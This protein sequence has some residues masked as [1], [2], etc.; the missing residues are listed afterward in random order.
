MQSLTTGK[1]PDDWLNVNII[2]VLKRG[3]K[4]YPQLS[5]YFFNFSLLQGIRAYYSM[6]HH[7][8]EHLY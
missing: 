5:S 1:L 8:V 2:P 7:I 3:Q 6:Y 4:W